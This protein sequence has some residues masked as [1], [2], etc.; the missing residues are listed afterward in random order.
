M[1]A[2][3]ARAIKHDIKQTYRGSGKTSWRENNRRSVTAAWR[4]AVEN[5]EHRKCGVGIGSSVAR[6]IAQC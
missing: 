3:P 5:G 2:A 4:S 1:A 6:I